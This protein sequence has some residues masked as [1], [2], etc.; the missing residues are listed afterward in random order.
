MI[1]VLDFG[2]QYT[3]LIARRVRELKIYSEIFP[4]NVSEET[5]KE[6]G[7]KVIILSGGPGSANEQKSY[8]PDKRIFNG[9]YLVLGI[10]YGMQIMGRIFGSDISKG[11]V[12]EYGRT[13]FY[14]EKDPVFEGIK[15]PG[16]VWMSHYDVVE[17]VPEDFYSIGKTDTCPIAAFRNKKGTFYGLQFHPEVIH[18]E[19]GKKILKN[20]LYNIAKLK[21][22][23][24]SS[25]MVDAAVKEIKEKVGTSK[26]IC[27]LSG[28]VD[29][30]TLAMLVH[31]AIGEN[32]LV[33]F[34]DN[35]L[36]RK[37]EG[38]E[39]V[40]RFSSI[41]NMRYIEA[42]DIFLSNLK[43]VKDPEE[44]RKIIGNTFIKIFEKQ[45]EN[46]GA[47]FLAQGTLYPDLIESTP[48]FGGPT[49][50]IKT[51]HN[52]GGLPEKMKLKLVEPF[53]YMFKDEVRLIAKKTGLPESMIERHPF[54]G[55][56]LAIRIIGEIDDEKLEILRDA[57]AIFIEEIKKAQLYKKIWQAFTVLLPIKTVGIMGDMRTYQYVVSLRAVKSVDGMTADWYKIPQHVLD[58]VSNRIV[59]EVKKVNRI[60]YDITSK[61][62]ATIEWE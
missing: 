4:Y 55:P 21:P 60:V 43:G 35:G 53:K 27:A 36:L 40:K 20:F 18:T 49:A 33:V 32:S 37:D 25:S 24:T 17:N 45:A 28:G 57:D 44:K 16:T 23:W 1:A 34:V 52:V 3:Q 56:G 8:Q 41:L 5:L 26:V 59:N 62:P 48:A 58:K 13:T 7:I 61:P 38:K 22:D 11:S 31:R 51:H 29:S 2:S 9:D 12:R 46:F 10:C 42:S 54:P 14:P 15:E 30:S 39:I 19:D 47:R 50:I 6:R